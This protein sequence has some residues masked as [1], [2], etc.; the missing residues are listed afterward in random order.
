MNK[1]I[2]PTIIT[3]I[4]AIYI[5]SVITLTVAENGY[6]NELNECKGMNNTYI[7]ENQNLQERY[8][9]IENDN[10]QLRFELDSCERYHE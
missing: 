3:F 9:K 7:E 5:T 8:N 4:I 2:I 1:Y 10:M 6:K